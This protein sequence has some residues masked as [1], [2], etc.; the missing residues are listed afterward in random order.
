MSVAFN[1]LSVFRRASAPLVLAGLSMIAL[2]GYHPRAA[3][4][5][6][7]SIIS[8]S[9]GIDF[10]TNF[11]VSTML[12]PG[13]TIPG[14]LRSFQYT[15]QCSKSLSYLSGNPEVP[16]PYAWNGCVGN[17][18]NSTEIYPGVYTSGS[19]GIGFRIRN[20][21]G[22]VLTGA[23][24][25]GTCTYGSTTFGGFTGWLDASHSSWTIQGT[26]ELV[27]IPGEIG[28]PPPT[29]P[30]YSWGLAFA[31]KNVD[32]LGGTYLAWVNSGYDYEK[33]YPKATFVARP[34]TC[35]TTVPALVSLPP[36]ALSDI[37]TVGAVSPSTGF[38]LGLNCDGNLIAGV[39]FDSTQIADPTIGTLAVTSTDTPAVD[40][41][42][43]VLQLLD[44][45]DNA[46][47]LPGHT[48]LGNVTANT[49][50]TYPFK[51]RYMRQPGNAAG[52]N[53]SA[54]ATVTFDYK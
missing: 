11:A 54:T 48:D 45:N 8:G 5:D 52:G 20:L 14:T 4:A 42:G 27:R 34:V 22:Q 1:F 18:S 7:C 41:S 16:T 43:V 50:Y 30:Y 38:N 36:V 17:R 21:A 33:I 24:S 6:G 46:L 44:N 53:V 12:Q 25:P 51:V 26:M 15:G 2:L 32:S 40:Q 3:A 19:S 39:T 29:G 47:I 28:G 49:Q 10:G 9:R 37:G 23:G 35:N 13:D 31:M